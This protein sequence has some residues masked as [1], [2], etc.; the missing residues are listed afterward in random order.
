MLQLV[1]KL[2]Y[3]GIMNRNDAYA[4]LVAK[5]ATIAPDFG[6]RLPAERKLADIIG[7]SR[8]TLRAALDQLERQGEIWRGVGQG[9][10]R[11]SRPNH[12]PVRDTLLIDGATPVDLMSARM[13]LEPS[14]AAAA[15]RNATDTDIRFLEARVEQ[16]RTGTDRTACEQAD[17]AFHTGIAKVA[18]NPVLIGLMSYL[19]GARRRAAWQ[20][21]WDRAYRRLGVDEFRVDHSHQ[22]AAVVAAI[23]RGDAAAASSAMSEHLG[24]IEEALSLEGS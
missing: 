24:T 20:R 18:G 21:Q 17:D 8:A 9:T 23:A 10:F 3:T 6:D 1:C 16:G 13:V 2:V 14:V 22:H 11:G 19:S 4:A 7:C 15:A 5:L 12:M